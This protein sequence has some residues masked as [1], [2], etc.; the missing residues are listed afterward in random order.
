MHF[1]GYLAVVGESQS[2][3]GINAL[4][5]VGQMIRDGISTRIIALTGAG[6]STPS[7]LPDFRCIFIFKLYRV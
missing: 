1:T 4:K 5:Q 7:G 6:I 3:I 2:R